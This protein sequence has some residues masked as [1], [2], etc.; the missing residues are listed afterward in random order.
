MSDDTERL[1][2]DEAHELL[3]EAE[4]GALVVA[5]TE[6]VPAL[7]DVPDG[8]RRHEFTVE[9]VRFGNP[10]DVPDDVLGGGDS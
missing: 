5:K 8:E 9:S 3:D 1:T 10:R 4:F 6:P 2:V 7:G